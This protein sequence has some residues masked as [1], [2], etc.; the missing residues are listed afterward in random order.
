MKAT[1]SIRRINSASGSVC[2]GGFHYGDVDDLTDVENV[3][4][5]CGCT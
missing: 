1:A 3:D 5:L 2:F 4:G